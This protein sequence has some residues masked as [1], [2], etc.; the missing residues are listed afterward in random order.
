MK[1]IVGGAGSVGRS[2]IGYL[3][4]GSNDIVVVDTNQDKLNEIS[5]EFDIQ[6]VL[7]SISHPDI[8]EKIGAETA[9][10]L[11]AAT[12]NDEVNLVACQVAY[13]LFN[14]PKRIARIDSSYFL[15]PMWNTLYNEKSLPIDL[16]ISPDNEIAE[17]I[18]RVIDIAGTKEVYPLADD[19]IYVISFKC[20]NNCQLYNFTIE[21]IYENFKDKKFHILQILRNGQNFYPKTDEVLKCNDEIYM[22]AYKKDIVSLLHDFGIEQKIN[23]NVV[24]FGGNAIAQDLAQKLEDND[25]ILSCKIIT[26]N[27]KSASRLAE[28]LDKTVVIQGEMMSD[29]I[30]KDAGIDSADITV[31]VTEQDKDNLLVS[32]LAHHNHICST[33]SLVNSRAYDSL[34]DNIGDNII[35]DRSAVTISKIL[36]DI[37]KTGLTNAYSL[38]RGFGELWEIK[39]KEDQ[40]VTGKKIS[41]LNMPERCKIAAILRNDEIILKYDDITLSEGDILILFVNPLGIKKMEQIFGY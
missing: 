8:Q 24:I 4:R 30:L 37:R 32:L 28:I 22:L 26:N 35:I 11:I 38:G 40:P 6:P 25:N 2:I 9:D 15:N 29:V 33:V 21:D 20:N 10:I 1:I 14:V 36:Q 34:I 3:S 16:V 19:K 31:A 39:L 27:A 41:D 7:G 18:L 17:A 23:E 13:S 12:S 5:R